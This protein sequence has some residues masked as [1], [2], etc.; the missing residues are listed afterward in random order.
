M[1]VANGSKVTSS[2]D[3]YSLRDLPV[4]VTTVIPVE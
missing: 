3:W 2:V 4:T 1:F